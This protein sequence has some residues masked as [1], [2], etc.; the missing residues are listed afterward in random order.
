[1]II[2]FKD[3]KLNSAYKDYMNKKNKSA[4]DNMEFVIEEIK[5]TISILKKISPECDKLYKIT[6]EKVV[7]KK[8]ASGGDLIT[9][10]YL[11]PSPIS[12]IVS[13]NCSRGKMIKD[14]S[15]SKKISYE[16]G[17][18]KNNN[19]IIVNYLISDLHEFL[20]YDDDNVVLGIVFKY[21]SNQKCDILLINKCIYDDKGKIISYIQSECLDNNLISFMN[22][23]NYS[24]LQLKLKYADVSQV[25]IDNE[26]PVINHNKYIFEH[27]DNGYLE[28]YSIEPY[29]FKD[30]RFKIYKR[31][32]L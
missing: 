9:R 14:L 30:N 7:T 1:M 3:E 23:E 26:T 12:D 5:K 13:G 24:Y 4:D 21:S 18:D 31:I 27:D 16:Y 20:L 15:R 2:N 22:I 17:F 25:A 32:K 11:C 28:Y 6:K 29:M 8:Y 10:G 19:L